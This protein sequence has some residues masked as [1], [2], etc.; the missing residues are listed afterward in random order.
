M[1]RQIRIFSGMGEIRQIMSIYRQVWPASFGIMDLLATATECFLLED[2]AK[3]VVGYAFVEEDRKRGFV[4]LQDIAILP[5]YRG[6][7]DGARLMETIM[8]RYPCIKLIARANNEPLVSFYR[9][10]GF[11]V[12][13]TIENYYDIDQDGLRMTWGSGHHSRVNK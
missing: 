8:E 5:E 10:M 7:K 3:Q 1:S 2:E 6:E 11:T 4:E 12:E 13:Q 9:K